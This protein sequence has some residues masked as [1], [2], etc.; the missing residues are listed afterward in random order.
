M[1]LGLNF[2][3]KTVSYIFRRSSALYRF[4]SSYIKSP[5]ISN[6]FTF[7][8]RYIHSIPHLHNPFSKRALADTSFNCF[9]TAFLMRN[10]IRVSE[11]ALGF[12]TS[13]EAVET[14]NWT[15][16]WPVDTSEDSSSK[17]SSR[18]FTWY[19]CRCM[20]G[21]HVGATMQGHATGVL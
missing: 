21:L 2:Q 17:G 15:K 8:F 11:S 3:H 1:K 4:T 20:R 5:Q 13:S 14:A 12:S 6:N 19:S 16:K 9:A 7:R 18:T 10:P